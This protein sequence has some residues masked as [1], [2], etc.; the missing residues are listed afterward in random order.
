MTKT[1]RMNSKRQER[2][3]RKERAERTEREQRE[4][5]GESREKEEHLARSHRPGARQDR[6]QPDLISKLKGIIRAAEAGHLA[7]KQEPQASGT[8]TTGKKGKGKGKS[9]QP[10]DNSGKSGRGRH[11][12]APKATPR[13]SRGQ[14]KVK[15][16]ARATARRRGAYLLNHFNLRPDDWKGSDIVKIGY[17]LNKLGDGEGCEA[18]Q[19]ACIA[20]EEQAEEAAYLWKQHELR[21]QDK[22]VALVVEARG[23]NEETW[24]CGDENT[25]ARWLRVKARNEERVDL[26]RVAILKLGTTGE[27]PRG[28]VIKSQANAPVKKEKKDAAT[29]RVCI[30]ATDFD[31][32]LTTKIANDLL[33]KAW[34]TGVRAVSFAVW[35]TENS[36]ENLVAYMTYAMGTEAVIAKLVEQSGNRGVFVS[37]LAR[38]RQQGRSSVFWTVRARGLSDLHYFAEVQKQADTTARARSFTEQEV[39]VT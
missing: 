20:T 2:K 34:P 16:R 14:S 37:R 3:E 30:N 6:Q 4:E 10:T 25:A 23:H 11:N 36:G 32:E 27:P 28:P 7:P 1:D 31:E 38:D 19:T 13:R 18:K 17:V 12:E 22:G 15:A 35:R 33:Q 21:K 39:E 26:K 29:V 8:S 5:Q 9:D 24:K